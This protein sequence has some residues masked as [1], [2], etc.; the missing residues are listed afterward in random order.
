MADEARVFYANG[1][2]VQVGLAD[3]AIHFT[4]NNPETGCLTVC[5]VHVPPLVAKG[6]AL[7]LARA[8][9]EHERYEAE[10]RC[11]ETA[12]GGNEKAVQ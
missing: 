11:V 7:S 3:F 8:V 6:L 4:L 5:W 2:G 12:A 1:G 10:V 9:E